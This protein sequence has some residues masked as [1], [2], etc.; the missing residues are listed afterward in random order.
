MRLFLAVWI[1]PEL[2][3]TL[4]DYLRVVS[5]TSQGI[6][7]VRPEQ[8]HITL[9]FLGEQPLDVVERLGR[10]IQKT[11]FDQH[12]FQLSFG[13]GGWFPERG[14]P[15]VLW[16]G[17]SEGTKELSAL[18]RTVGDVCGRVCAIEDEKPFKP[19]LTLGRIKNPPGSFDQALLR[20]G[21]PGKMK[22]LEFSLV[23]S[24]LKSTGPA[25]QDVIR[26]PL[27]TRR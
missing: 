12:P 8:Y 7:W 3:Q 21:C 20:R 23:E 9:K 1:S 2:R 15:R 10:E 26:F 25:Y 22:V 17:F 24:V 11:T 27:G 6:R 4:N 16:M 18:A 5:S 13:T 14:E 19:H